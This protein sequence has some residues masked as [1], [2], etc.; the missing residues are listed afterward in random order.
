MKIFYKFV[1]TLITRELME[2]VILFKSCFIKIFVTFQLVLSKPLTALTFATITSLSLVTRIGALGITQ[3]A[4]LFLLASF[5]LDFI[6]GVYASY[7]ETKA[8]IQPL[9]KPNTRWRRFL[10][11]IDTLGKT[12]SSEKLR[13]SVVKAIA[14][15]L[16]V[17]CTYGIQIIFFVK[18]FKFSNISD[19]EFTVTLVVIGFCII[20]ELWS[21][22][23]ENL[24]RAGYD[25][26][27]AIM[28]VVR[29][30]KKV[31]KEVEE[32]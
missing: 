14:Y 16:I 7:V 24:P 5:I 22:F 20:T 15:S 4:L 17:M 23:K 25:I 30:V 9:E 27:G 12:I 3:Q 6:T 21:V 32:E 2:E 10:N 26:G 19:R 31:K 18:K 29:G 1:A 28:N 11:M 8:K 13:K